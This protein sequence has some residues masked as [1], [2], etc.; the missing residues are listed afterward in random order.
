[1]TGPDNVGVNH[2]HYENFPVAS[3]LCPPHLRPPILAIYRF[4]RTADDIA[5]E[6]T[7]SAAERLQTL[8]NYA[9]CLD[10]ALRGKLI[11]QWPEVFVPLTLA[12]ESHALS[13]PLLHD[14]LSAFSQ[15]CLNP[16]YADRSQLLDYC[17]RSASPIGRLLLGL[18]G[19]DDVTSL[20]RSDAVCTALQL[21]NFWQDPSV[22]LARGRNY[23]PLE[24]L[25]RQGLSHAEMVPGNDTPATQAVLADLTQWAAQWM[26]EGSSL[27]HHLPGRMGWELR[28][29]VQ[30][31]LQIVAKIRQ[32]EHRTLGRRPRLSAMDYPA[33]L[34][35]AARMGSTRTRLQA[36]NHDA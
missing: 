8:A 3:L 30:G 10:N 17:R 2:G 4:A 34:W 22:D 9:T 16:L 33:L 6:G 26:D 23:F 29:V 11:G 14:L 12:A 31:G 28:L 32:M 15:D 24:D 18:Y 35:R 7:A 27:V 36:A 5:D 21:I 20:A 1:M 13:R 25:Q 19:I